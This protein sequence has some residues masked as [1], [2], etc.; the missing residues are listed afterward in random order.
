[1]ENTE[2]STQSESTQ[3][4]GGSKTKVIVIAIVL[5]LLLGIGGYIFMGKNANKPAVTQTVIEP[6]SSPT[7][8]NSFS[9]IQEAL[10]KSISL[11]CDYTDDS[12]SKVM[13][14]MK[15][16]A[17]RSDI[18]AKSVKNSGSFIMKDKKMYYWSGK[19]GTMIEFDITALTSITPPSQN[20]LRKYFE[21]EERTKRHKEISKLFEVIQSN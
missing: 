16:G 5:F 20:E 12:G 1:M 6:E 17:I 13:S 3:K 10:S 2:S 14:Y 8:D 18:T 9:T 11:Q 21:E 19:T 4:T 7:P 15:N